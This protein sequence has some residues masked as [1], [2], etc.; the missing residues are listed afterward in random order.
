[1][2]HPRIGAYRE[3]VFDALTAEEKD[4]YMRL[5]NNYYYQRHNHFWASMAIRRLKDIYGE[6][7]MLCCAEDLG[8]LPDGVG[9]VLDQLRMLSL[10]I[11]SMPK[12]N[13]FEFAHLNANPYRS[14]ATITTHDMSPLR[15][16][17][18]ESPERTQR[19]YVTMIQ[20]Q[21]HAPEHLPAHLA[22]EIVARHLYCPSMLCVLSLQDWLAMDGELRSKSPREERINIPGDTHNRWKYRMHLTLEELLDA[23]RY[24]NKV[25]T[26]ITRSKR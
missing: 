8:M 18:E 16:W 13:G 12:Q 26:M 5:Y 3:P 11:Q 25:R 22:E 14:V 17:W 10:E 21:G 1:M 6:S 7:K 2:Y 15:L 23:T 4:A 9:H 24:N 20:K 19:Y